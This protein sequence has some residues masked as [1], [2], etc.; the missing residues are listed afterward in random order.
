[1][2]YHTPPAVARRLGVAP[3]KVLQLI[4][5]G[6]IVAHDLATRRGG[7]PRWRISD[8]ALDAF[9]ESRRSQPTL[10]RRKMRK[11]PTAIK[12]YF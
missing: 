1:M 2:N 3:E 4:R 8:E 11:P 9:L 6:E 12:Q 7:R 5:T 10:P